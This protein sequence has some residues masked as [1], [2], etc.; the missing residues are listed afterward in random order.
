MKDFAISPDDVEDSMT[1]VNFSR[2]RADIIGGPGPDT[3]GDSMDLPQGL[4]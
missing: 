2:G 3:A 1:R 4:R